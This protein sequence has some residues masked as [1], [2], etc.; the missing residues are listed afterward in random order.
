MLLYRCPTAQFINRF[1][2]KHTWDVKVLYDFLQ[3]IYFT[4]Q[5]LKTFNMF[6]CNTYI[7]LATSIWFIIKVC[8]QKYN[9]L[10]TSIINIISFKKFEF[11]L[12]K[13]TFN[14]VM[15]H[16]INR[17]KTHGYKKQ[18]KTSTSEPLNIKN[19][20]TLQVVRF[21]QHRILYT[22]I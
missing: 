1:L 15:K 2:Q 5:D 14:D 17:Y 18:Y 6:P 12:K 22:M 16:Q 9:N 7:I 19:S 13:V 4:F 8:L 10:E 21:D 11:F 20:A 3:F